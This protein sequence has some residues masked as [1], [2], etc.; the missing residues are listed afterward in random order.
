MSFEQPMEETDPK[1]FVKVDVEDHWSGCFGRERRIR[2]TLEGPYLLVERLLE[3]I[4]G[5]SGEG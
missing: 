2:Y 3:K 1:T 5:E 4:K